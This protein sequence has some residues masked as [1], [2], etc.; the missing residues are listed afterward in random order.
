MSL[1]VTDAE[2]ELLLEVLEARYKSML[3]ELHHTDTFE[4]KELLEKKVELL[5]SLK[6]KLLRPSQSGLVEAG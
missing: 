3:H 1:L 6:E 4:Y 2:R 5:E